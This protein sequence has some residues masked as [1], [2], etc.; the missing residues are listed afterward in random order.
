MGP[1]NAKSRR[2]QT[3]IL[4]VLF[5]L[6]LVGLLTLTLDYGFVLLS[7][8]TMQSAVNTGAL[9]G[10]R[11]IDQRGRMEAREVIRNVFD[12]DLDPTD[13]LS[14]L[15]AGPEQ[16]LV[17][18]DG[19][20]RPRFAARADASSLFADRHE[21]VYRPVPELNPD[22]EIHGDLVS[23]D[24]QEN[25]NSHAEMRNYQR[26]DF[27]ASIQGQAF[28]ARIRRTP[29]RVG[30]ATPLDRIEGVSSS[31]NGS[32]LLVGHLL[33]FIPNST[34]GF[35]LRRDG[36]TVRATAISDSR[37]IVYVG[38]GVDDALYSAT[39]YG[40]YPDADFHV[41]DSAP[42]RLGE[43]VSAGAVVDERDVPTGYVAALLTYE[44]NDYVVGFMLNINASDT[45]SRKPNA[46]PRLH[47]AMQTL[48]EL[49]PKVR[50]AVLARHRELAQ[51]ENSV[52]A[53][54][55]VLVRAIR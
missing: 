48:N 52:L 44:Q 29:Q 9:E 40:V 54:S 31:G 15:G 39:S 21:Y 51:E 6:V 4:L 41:L 1:R 2:G 28:L 8:R 36:V 38:T 20:D 16:T 49:P 34:A 14:T 32:P 37:P 27:N 3:L 33:P 35:D 45:D 43:I 25:A 30:V 12:D 10:A 7:R 5:L 22:N 53:R 18:R 11:D 42:R 55:P 47:D 13:N 26:V 46:S 17:Q 50:D 24:Y 23:G 19:N